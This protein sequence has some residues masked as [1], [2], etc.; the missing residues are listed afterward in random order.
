MYFVVSGSLNVYKSYG[1]ANEM[2]LATLKPGSLFG[3]ISLFLK[4]PRTASIIANEQ[5][6]VMEIKESDMYNFMNSKPDIAY[7][8]VEILCTRLKNMLLVFDAY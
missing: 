8:I 3:E 7:F 2:L 4:E 5:V 1:K 6:T